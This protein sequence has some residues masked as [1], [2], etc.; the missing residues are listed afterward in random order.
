[1]KR[2]RIPKPTHL[3]VTPAAAVGKPQNTALPAA[4]L[5]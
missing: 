5:R 1:M 4:A 2:L 3:G